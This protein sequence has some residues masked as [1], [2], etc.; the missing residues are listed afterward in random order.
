MILLFLL[1][2]GFDELPVTGYW[3]LPHGIEEFG[4][5]QTRKEMHSTIQQ[6]IVYEITLEVIV[7]DSVN[8][9]FKIE[10]KPLK[11]IQKKN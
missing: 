2:Y 7:Y 1:D 3:N 8:I 4:E 10:A 11:K 5:D 6:T 9:S